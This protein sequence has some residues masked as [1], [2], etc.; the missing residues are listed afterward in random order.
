MN[1]IMLK[2]ILIYRKLFRVIILINIMKLSKFIDTNETYYN[3]DK[4]YIKHKT[5]YV[6]LAPP[7]SGKTIFVNKQVGKNS[8]ID[9][10]ILFNK[11]NLNIN[12]LNSTNSIDER[13]SYL[14][15]DYMLEQSKLYGYRIIG[16]LFWEYKAD[17][18][19]ILPLKQHILYFSKRKDLDLSKIFEFRRIF[20]EHA[21]KYNIPIFDNIKDTI[22]YLE[23]KKT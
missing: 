2:V 20:Y 8:W 10:D 4:N 21:K 18:V 12:W 23:Y 19:V 14:R 13:L 7:A 22:T 16:A 9:S 17:A 15:A 1:Y 5:G 11:E 3:L 6:I